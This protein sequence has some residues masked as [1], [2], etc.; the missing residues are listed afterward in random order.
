[1]ASKCQREEAIKLMKT[2]QLHG[3]IVA[4]CQEE[5]GI[6]CPSHS[7]DVLRMQIRI[8]LIQDHRGIDLVSNTWGLIDLNLFTGGYEEEPRIWGVA[9]SCH[10]GLEVEVSDDH[11]L[12]EI[13]YQGK[14]INVNGDQGPA[15]WAQFH[16][17]Y[18]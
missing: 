2:H 9:E 3:Q 14:S 6:R 7:C 5:A 17:C 4:P 13:D 15:I 16:S 8:F 12:D 10:L 11:F 18:V 1:M